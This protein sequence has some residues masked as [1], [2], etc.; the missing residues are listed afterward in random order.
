MSRH[1]PSQEFRL[2]KDGLRRLLLLVGRVSILP[3]D[4]LDHRPELGPS[5]FLEVQWIVTFW[6]TV[7]TSSRAMMRRLSS[8]RILTELSEQHALREDHIQCFG[9][10]LAR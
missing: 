9:N 2:L 3:E 8:A 1:L 5:R 4:P 6:R 7:S 10:A